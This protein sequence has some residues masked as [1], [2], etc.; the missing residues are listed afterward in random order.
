MATMLEA[1][2]SFISIYS[3]IEITYCVY[4]AE[5]YA[6]QY[7]LGN[8]KKKGQDFIFSYDLKLRK[9]ALVHTE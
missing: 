6:N 3:I 5:Y 9:Y 1:F 4:Q 7:D 8:L 2:S